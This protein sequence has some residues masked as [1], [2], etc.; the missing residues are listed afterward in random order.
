MGGD[1]GTFEWLNAPET[2]AVVK[3]LGEDHVRFVGGAVRDS[4]LGRQ[5]EDIDIATDLIPDKILKLLEFNDI[6]AVPTGIE[7][8]TI[9]AVFPGRAYEITTLRADVETDGRHAK[10]K[11]IDDWAGDASRRDFTINALYMDVR[12]EI[13]DYS[14]G[15]DDLAK[16]IVRFIGDAATRMEEDALRILRFF[17][18]HAHYAEGPL[19]ENVLAVIA[20]NTALLDK[21]SPERVT[22]EISKLLMAPDPVPVI[23]LMQ[24]SGV[25]QKF[26]PVV[27]LD[28]I[29]R[30]CEIETV[31]GDRSLLRRYSTILPGNIGD[32]RQSLAALRLNRHQQSHL[33]SLLHLDSTIGVGMDEKATHEALYYHHYLTFCDTLVLNSSLEDA[34][35]IIDLCKRALGCE[36]PKFPVKGKDLLELGF[37]PGPN[38]GK[39][40]LKM[41]SAWIASDFKLSKEK[42][43][44]A[45]LDE[46]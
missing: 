26:M 44:Q 46:Q 25:W 9:A 39:A 7:H 20:A 31:V 17:R 40:L 16:G 37:E 15:L 29:S 41:E 18:F 11:F 22:T 19:D 28:R 30:L 24:Q 4:L 43:L 14:T 13:T 34:D 38:F 36:I 5:I 21:L 32:L 12:G 42:L 1:P 33:V 45:F 23:K 6:R 2:E 8:G 3:A 10:V 27:P 35:Q